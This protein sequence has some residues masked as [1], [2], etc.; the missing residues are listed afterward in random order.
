M[1]R[2]LIAEQELSSLHSIIMEVQWLAFEAVT[3]IIFF[4]VTGYLN[5]ASDH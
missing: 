3:T 2:K 4:C 5:I 1:E